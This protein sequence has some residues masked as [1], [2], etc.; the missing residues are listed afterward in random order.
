MFLFITLRK[1]GDM[2]K[3]PGTG[4]IRYP[5]EPWLGTGCELVENWL[6]WLSGVNGFNQL[7]SEGG[8]NGRHVPCLGAL[9][10]L[11][12]ICARF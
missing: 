4:A 3:L 6:S 10:P 8:M 11:V 5:Q 12:L 7:A 9:P 1:V 2:E